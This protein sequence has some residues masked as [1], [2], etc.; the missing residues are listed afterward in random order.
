M[1][2]LMIIILIFLAIIMMLIT[3]IYREPWSSF[4]S[5]I[6]WFVCAMG[7]MKIEIPY[8][9]YNNSANK[10]V[11]STYSYNAAELSYVFMMI[12]VVMFIS[13]FS[14]ILEEFGK[15]FYK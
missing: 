14:L 15:S 13:F 11:T 8:Q 4:A 2:D 7:M 9:I 6:I 5:G 10:I 1:L 3:Y 12:G